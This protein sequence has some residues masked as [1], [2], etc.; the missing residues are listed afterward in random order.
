MPI[1]KSV[2]AAACLT[3]LAPSL[4]RAAVGEHGLIPQALSVDTTG[5]HTVVVT[6]PLQ[7][8]ADATTWRLV[9]ELKLGNVAGDGP[10]GFG[11][12]RDLAVDG[13]GRIYL[14][15]VAAEEVRVFGRDGAYLGSMARDGDGPGEFRYQRF[16]EPRITWRTPDQLWIGDGQRHVVLDTL[17]QELARSASWRG[18][19]MP[20]EFPTSSKVI[21]SGTDG[22]LFSVVDVIAIQSPDQA[23]V[24]LHT[25]VVHSP[26]TADH[27][28]L[29]GDTLA[30]ET[31]NTEM[32][33]GAEPLQGRG[34][35]TTTLQ[36]M[37]PPEE[38]RFV[39]TVERDGTLWLAH[40][41]RYRFDKL[42]FVGDTVLTVKMGEIPPLPS[43][44]SD[45]APVVASLASS[46]EGW[47]WVERQHSTTEEST[48]DVL[49][50][51]GRYRATVTAPVGL[52]RPEVGHGGALYG[53]SSNEL[54][55]DF[56]YRFRL[57]E[58]GGA[59]V[60]RETCPF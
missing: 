47:L 14:L 51:C 33:G 40:R 38:P 42:T 53:I 31:R 60:A 4:I 23:V 56:V 36:R 39:W 35:S 12:L 7:P 24:P 46:P 25:Y 44:G 55:V 1:M 20:G 19:F 50:N 17:G 34:G 28:V 2:I 13:I 48:W 18:F 41:S 16:S 26:V 10:D 6:E 45:F 3:L 43:A 29:P 9:E 37:Q 5:S 11:D 15:D 21:A 49:D 22:S 52:S 54:G 58:E 30:I 32:G 57:Q 59:Q 27:E 8:D